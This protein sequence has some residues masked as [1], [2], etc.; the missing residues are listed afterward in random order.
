M[1]DYEHW[2]REW[3]GSGAN[4]PELV[5]AIQRDAIESCAKAMEAKAERCRNILSD[6]THKGDRLMLRN[7]AEAYGVAAQAIKALAP[8]AKP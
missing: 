6:C 4:W 8:E 5:R 7:R 1:R 2:W 3:Q